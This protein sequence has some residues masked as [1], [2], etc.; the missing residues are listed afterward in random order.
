MTTKMDAVYEG[1]KLVLPTPL[2]LPDKTRVIVTI[3]SRT[4]SSD[5]E[6][7]AWLTLSEQSLLSTWNNPADDIFN[8]LLSK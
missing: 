6:R 4:Q 1:G 2:P 7:E 5:I 3:E 8:E